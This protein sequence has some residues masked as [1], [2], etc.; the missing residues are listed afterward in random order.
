VPLF[1]F[2]CKTCGAVFE[3]IVN[4]DESNHLQKCRK[5]GILN[6]AEK[7]LSTPSKMQ[8][9]GNGQRGF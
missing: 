7:I 5:C 8:W 3:K 9:G 4:Y 6:N 2:K 1:E